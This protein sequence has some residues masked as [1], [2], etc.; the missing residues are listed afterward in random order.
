M[1]PNPHTQ[2]ARIDRDIPRLFPALANSLGGAIFIIILLIAF[3]KSGF[4]TGTLGPARTSAT[5]NKPQ[6]QSTKP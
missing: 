2:N 4:H 5:D 6:S 3:L 1:K